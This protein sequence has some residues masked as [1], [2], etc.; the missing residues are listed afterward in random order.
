MFLRQIWLCNFRNYEEISLSFGARIT[1]LQAKNSQGKTNLLE[2]IYYLSSLSSP[3]C[4]RPQEMI[5]HGAPGFSIKG[6]IEDRISQRE[7]AIYLGE[8]TRSLWAGGKKIS[9][10]ARYWGKFP[11]VMFSPDDLALV[12]GGDEFRRRFLDRCAALKDRSH[13]GELAKLRKVL[14]HRNRLLKS[15]DRRQ[16][17]PWD[18][19]LA[20]LWERIFRSRMEIVEKL[21]ASLPS[22]LPALGWEKEAAIRYRP[23]L[24]GE[25][26]FPPPDLAARLGRS[27]DQE[28]KA[29]C[30]LFG[31]HRD[32]I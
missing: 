7:L 29:G 14:A 24:T 25:G 8:E 18:E 26:T 21:N 11:T 20:T 32:E 19:Q 23:I 17:S 2:A 13:L 28:M 22:L 3:R 30:S 9:H 15:G 5:R 10:P 12:A 31:P 16:L 27:W 6:R 4:S 1:I